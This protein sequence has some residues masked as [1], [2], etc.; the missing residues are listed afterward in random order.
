MIDRYHLRYFLAVA[1]H[2]NF[3]K[4]AH[5]CN[6]SQPTL[7]VG[8]AKLEKS[9]SKALYN[10]TNRRVEL[11]AAGGRLLPHARR[12]E[13]VFALAERD[14]AGT[15]IATTIRI[16]V[17]T[18]TPRIWIE[19]FLGAHKRAGS[20]EQIEILEGRER[21][22]HD[23]LVRGRIDVALTIIRDEPSK[24]ERETLFTEGYSLA[25]AATHPL[26]ERAVISAEELVNEPMILRRQCELLSETSRY[27]TARRVRPFFPARTMSDDRAIGY[28]RAGLGI[29]VMPD[30]FV[31]QGIVKSHL[32]DFAFTREIGLLY[33]PHVSGE[34]LRS[35]QPIRLLVQTIG[36]LRPP[37]QIV[38][39]GL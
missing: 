4:A 36:Q 17:L 20:G 13:E 6:V 34:A 22:L 24:R 31:A 33:A 8:I 35:S 32:K 9:L 5:A 39:K 26:A 23:R 2:G 10:R 29:T 15:D 12:I 21:D 3:S 14:I 11:T 1:D 28:V 27:F 38:V 19:Q 18:T 37:P 7:S 16:G 30:S 25:M